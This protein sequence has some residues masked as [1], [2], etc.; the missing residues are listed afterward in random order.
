[1]L[2]TR[3]KAVNSSRMS[4]K[5]QASS[6]YVVSCHSIKIGKRNVTP[7]VTMN[8]RIGEVYRDNFKTSTDPVVL[9]R[10]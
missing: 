6:T 10:F 1:M 7:I 2:F 9:P 4:H 3:V 8:R 5:I